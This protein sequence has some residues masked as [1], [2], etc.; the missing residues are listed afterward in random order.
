MKLDVN[1]L[2]Q[3]DLQAALF[4]RSTSEILSDF[5]VD[6]L[7]GAPKPAAVLIPMFYDRN[8][9]HV[10]FIRRTS[11]L[12]EHGGQVAFPGGRS[13]PD[14]QSAIETALRETQE[15]IGL[16]PED[17]VVLGQLHKLI[18]I[19]NY[20]VT[21]FIGIIPWPYSFRR[22]ESEV[23]R[24][25]SIPLEWLVDPQNYEERQRLLPEPYAPIKVIYFKPYDQEILWGVS[26]RIVL[27]FIDLL[28][29]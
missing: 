10:L 12:A 17:V 15:E 23:A 28:T 7:T 27:D 9:W 2:T 6:L 21:P 26:A 8:A 24:I 11:S 19:T 25:F 20:E 22:A 1:R 16:V 13:D 5:P 18:T 3:E 29:T 4:A 14:D